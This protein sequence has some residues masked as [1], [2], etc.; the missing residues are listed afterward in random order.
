MGC[1]PCREAGIKHWGRCHRACLCAEICCEGFTARPGQCLKLPGWLCFW[2]DIKAQEIMLKQVVVLLLSGV[3]RGHQ[4]TLAQ[5]SWVVSDLIWLVAGMPG[6]QGAAGISA[7]VWRMQFGFVCLRLWFSFPGFSSGSH[8]K[9]LRP[10]DEICVWPV[11][12]ERA[13]GGAR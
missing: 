7:A 12:E 5:E 11:L 3:S 10:P 2:P 13:A 8:V 1:P 9:H 6:V 4:L